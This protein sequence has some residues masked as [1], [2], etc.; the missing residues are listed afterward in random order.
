MGS[1]PI[2]RRGKKQEWT[3]RNPLPAVSPT[4][5]S[6]NPKEALELEWLYRVVSNLSETKGPSHSLID[7]SLNEVNPREWRDPR[8]FAAEAITERAKGQRL[9]TSS[10]SSPRAKRPSVKRDPGKPSRHLLH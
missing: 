2:E 7:Q 4:A 5:A 9:S 1:T 3:E 8:Y 10:T 6:A